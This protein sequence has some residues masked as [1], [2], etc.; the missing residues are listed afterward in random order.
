MVQSVPSYF[1]Q[2]PGFNNLVAKNC[3]VYAQKNDSRCSN[4]QYHRS[5]L[6]QWLSVNRFDE[7]TVLFNLGCLFD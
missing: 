6:H 3:I 4:K 5:A 7:K 2:Y 1:L